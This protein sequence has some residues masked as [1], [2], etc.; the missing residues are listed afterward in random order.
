MLSAT[1]CLHQQGLSGE[2]TVFPAWTDAGILAGCTKTK[3]VV[4][5]PGD[6]ALAH[7]AHELIETAELQ[8]A[9]LFYAA[10]AEDYCQKD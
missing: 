2:P 6:L 1:R 3:C 9:A 7:T 4:I 10:L 8:K 5:G